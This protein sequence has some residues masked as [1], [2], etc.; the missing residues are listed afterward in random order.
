MERKDKTDAA[1]RYR[2]CDLPHD[3]AITIEIRHRLVEHNSI[4]I[5]FVARDVIIQTGAGQTSYYVPDRVVR[6]G[7]EV[8]P[9]RL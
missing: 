7:L 4:E 5:R 9:R 6:I 3:V 1:G 8:R 2:L